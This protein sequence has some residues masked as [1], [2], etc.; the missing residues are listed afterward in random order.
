[1][2]STTITDIENLRRGDHI[3]HPKTQATVRVEGVVVR[4]VVDVWVSDFDDAEPQLLF[5]ARAAD[6]PVSLVCWEE[7]RLTPREVAF[8]L[9]KLIEDPSNPLEDFQL[10]PG[11]KRWALW[12]RGFDRVFT[13]KEIL[14]WLTVVCTLTPKCDTIHNS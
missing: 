12:G 9:L 2:I 14:E 3:L 7:V 4:Q 5:S 8:E 1:M 11:E 10:L 6:T 13:D